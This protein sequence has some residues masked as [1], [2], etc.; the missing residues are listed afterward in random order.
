ML[1]NGYASL[2]NPRASNL[3][4]FESQQPP[5]TA[6]PEPDPNASHEEIAAQ[7]RTQ[8]LASLRVLGCDLSGEQL[9]D[10][11]GDVWAYDAEEAAEDWWVEWGLP[12]ERAK[13]AAPALQRAA[14]AVVRVE[15][16]V[17]L[18]L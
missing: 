12:A 18:V 5:F 17:K 10:A 15:R 13:G 3:N 14:P 7:I 8:Y 9:W 16:E 1:L 11:V 2:R 6:G 4:A